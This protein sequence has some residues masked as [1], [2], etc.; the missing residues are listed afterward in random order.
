[1]VGI[2]RSSWW[3]NLPAAR[4]NLSRSETA[5]RRSVTRVK[6]N[7]HSSL[8]RHGWDRDCHLDTRLHLRWS[9]LRLRRLTDR[10]RRALE[11]CDPIGHRHIEASRPASH[12]TAARARLRSPRHVHRPKTMGWMGVHRS[13]VEECSSRPPSPDRGRALRTVLWVR[14]PLLQTSLQLRLC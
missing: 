4:H 2:G 14:L 8:R 6:L 9:P 3:P 1:M 11:N 7:F 10:W 12:A 13:G 5:Q